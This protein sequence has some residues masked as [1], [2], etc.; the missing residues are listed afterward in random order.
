MA[1]ATCAGVAGKEGTKYGGWKRPAGT[2][3]CLLGSNSPCLVYR[4][5]QV[6]CFQCYL[7]SIPHYGFSLFDCPSCIDWTNHSGA[8]QDHGVFVPA[9]MV[10]VQP[11]QQSK[12]SC[13]TRHS[14]YCCREPC[15]ILRAPVT[16]RA[17]GG[18]FFTL[19]LCR[20]VL[21]GA[22]AAHRMSAVAAASTHTHTEH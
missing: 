18:T 11:P 16:V 10:F 1:P 9:Y 6:V 4:M 14:D 12:Y 5:P 13:R 2:Q 7:S 17:Q 3:V 21:V 22:S 20:S 8:L 15:C 19:P